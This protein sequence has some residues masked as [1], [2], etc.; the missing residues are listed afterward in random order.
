MSVI[1]VKAVMVDIAA[2]V[3][4]V[5]ASGR[6]AS[7]R[8][9]EAAVAGDAIVGYP[10]GPI[11]IADTYGRGSD[12]LTLPLYIILGLPADESTQTALSTWVGSG[13]IVAAIESYAGTWQSVS[14][15]EASVETYTP[16]GGPEQLALRFDIDIL[17]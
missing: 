17:S 5:L 13:S 7:P 2:A 10:T 6:T 1:D 15:M 4:T 14:V 16:I 8:P 12:R 3:Q 11:S 9:V